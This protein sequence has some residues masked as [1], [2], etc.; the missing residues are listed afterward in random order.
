[1]PRKA[2]RIAAISRGR[3][4]GLTPAR[5]PVPL[6]GLLAGMGYL[7]RSWWLEPPSG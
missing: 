3:R 7:A 6:P 4:T 5:C 1:M 2:L